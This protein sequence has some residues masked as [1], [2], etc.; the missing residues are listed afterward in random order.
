MTHIHR[1]LLHP[2]ALH[3]TRALSS[4]AP[5]RITVNRWDCHP[6]FLH[7]ELYCSCRASGSLY[8]RIPLPLSPSRLCRYALHISKISSL[9]WV[10]SLQTFHAGGLCHKPFPSSA[11]IS[12]IHVQLPSLLCLP[13]H[14]PLLQHY[15][16]DCS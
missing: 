15:L 3:H 8:A 13:S 9:C 10:R 16:P 2:A 1:R 6:L 14:L 11:I 12:S 4:P 5:L 7:Q